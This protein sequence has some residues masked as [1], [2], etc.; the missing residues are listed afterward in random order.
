MAKC[1]RLRAANPIRIALK[2]S[3]TCV[4]L[5]PDALFDHCGQ[6]RAISQRIVDAADREVR[7]RARERRSLE[8]AELGDLVRVDARARAGRLPMAEDHEVLA[9]GRSAARA[10]RQEN[11]TPLE[12]TITVNG[13]PVGVASVPASNASPWMRRY[14]R[15]PLLLLDTRQTR[16]R[17]C[18]PEG[19]PCERATGH[20]K[21]PDGRGC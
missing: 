6:E 14:P 2:A 21:R 9:R 12:M 20:E 3:T 19:A 11:A 5:K 8:P 18:P 17:T 15:C 16:Q 10:Q 7:H 1:S 13:T 4:V